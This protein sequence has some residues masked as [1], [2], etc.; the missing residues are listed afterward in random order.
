M[1]HAKK[2][3]KNNYQFFTSEMNSAAQ[4][5]VK[6]EKHLRRALEQNGLGLYYQPQVDIETGLIIGMEALIRWFSPELGMVAPG[7]FIPLAEETG[8]IV[9]IGAWV[10][11]TACAQARIW[12]Q[13]GLPIR[14][15]VNLSSR[16]FHQVQNH[17][18]GRHP[19]L[20][21]VLNALDETGLPPELLE[22]EITE[23][24]LMHHLDTT[25]EILSTLK[26]RGV[27]L[28]VDDF[29]TGYSSLSYLK[30]FPIDTLKI[31]KSFVNDI[32]TDPSD[33]AIVAA[34]T[35]MAQQLKLEVVAEGV[36]SFAQLE[37]LRELRCH[38]VQG[39]YFSKPLPA[40]EVLFLLQQ[41]KFP[42]QAQ[43]MTGL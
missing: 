19:L 9:P 10:L 1:Y 20:D 23:G 12:Q 30:R 15:A 38:Y 28:S 22:L 41:G 32:T 4:N 16:Q 37:F 6:L 2:L 31:D 8:L 39:Y 33:K 29:G 27:R 25:M 34:I 35:V 17:Q 40:E 7:D 36:E 11:K 42:V 26:S 14:V 21:A 43:S 24:I 13:N 5:Y 3:G 18:Q